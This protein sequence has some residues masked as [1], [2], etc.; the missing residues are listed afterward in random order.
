MITYELLAKLRLEN[1]SLLSRM[2]QLRQRAETEGTT[3][4]SHE[5]SML[6]SEL[7]D[8]VCLVDALVDALVP[9]AP[10]PRRAAN[11]G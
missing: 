6:R 5:V 7:H 1:T 8:Y 11:G 2:D 3:A 10:A 9:D 4:L